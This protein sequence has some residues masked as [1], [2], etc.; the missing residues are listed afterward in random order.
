M[1]Y[2]NTPCRERAKQI[3]FMIAY[4]ATD[5]AIREKLGVSQEEVDEF[6]EI[7]A[8]RAHD[9]SVCGMYQSFVDAVLKAGGCEPKPDV[10]MQMTM[11]EIMY[12]Y[13][14][15]GVR[16]AFVPSAQL[17]QPAPKVNEEDL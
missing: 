14:T 4:G 17:D 7:V 8:Q 1:N 3:S 16:F 13:A 6:R 9:E 12:H 2:K 15:N 10:V 5:K 11:A